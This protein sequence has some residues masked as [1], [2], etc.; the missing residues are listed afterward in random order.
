MAINK[1]QVFLNGKV[2]TGRS[3][4]EFVSAFKIANGKISWIGDTREAE[5]KGAIDLEGKTVLQDSSM[6]ILTRPTSQ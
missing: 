6:S 3:E 4:K 2:F 5:K 1:E